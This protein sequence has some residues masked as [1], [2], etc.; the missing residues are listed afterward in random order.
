MIVFHHHNPLRVSPLLDSNLKTIER[1]FCLTIER[2][3]DHCIDSL[4][5]DVRF[6]K[7]H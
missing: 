7:M 3:T 4:R 1:L 6:F 2:I 5:D